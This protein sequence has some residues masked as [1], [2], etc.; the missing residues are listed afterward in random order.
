MNKINTFNYSGKFICTCGKEFT[1]SQSFNGHKSHCKQHLLEKGWIEEQL[2]ERKEKTLIPF[3][4]KNKREHEKAEQKKQQKL[5]QWLLEKHVCEKCGKLMTEKFRSGRFCCISCANS[6]V[7]TKE[8]KEKIWKSIN[9]YYGNNIEGLSY[10]E[11]PKKASKPKG[12]KPRFRKLRNTQKKVFIHKPKITNCII[13]GKQFERIGRTTRTTCSDECLHQLRIK[14][15]ID[16]IKKIGYHKTIYSQYK[17]GTYKGF[18]CD[19]SWELAFLV[20]CLDNNLLI[21]RNKIGFNYTY[22]N[23]ERTFFPDFLVNDTYYEIKGVW[24]EQ[25]I[26]KVNQFPKDK[27]LVII[28]RKAM[29]KYI[30]YCKSIYGKRFAETLYDN[31]KPNWTQSDKYKHFIEKDYHRKSI[32][33]VYY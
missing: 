12:N 22:K 33:D 25:V 14:R 17:F 6:R 30:D 29:K 10:T 4:N 24:T 11:R 26:E 21:E 9:K 20:Y 19:S 18:E 28:D 2:Q 7:R 13:C 8:T 1:N 32:S 15:S 23:T 3:K 16:N 5:E 31:D 27:K